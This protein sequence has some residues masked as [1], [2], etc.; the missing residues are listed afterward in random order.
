MMIRKIAPLAAAAALF[1]AAPAFAQS[2][3]DFTVGFGVHQVA[4]KSNNGKL[5]NNSVAVDVGNSLRPT[6]TGEYFVADNLG[7]EIIA[8]LPFSHEI[9]LAGVRA[10]ST[11]HLPPTLS[12]QYHFGATDAKVKP[13]LGAGVNYTYFYG[14]GLDNGAKL[15]LK[16]SWGAAAHA[17]IDF[18]LHERGAFR[19][20]VRWIDIDSKV[21]VGGA[22]VGTVNIDPLVYG[23]S[24]VLKF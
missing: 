20:D 16:N 2:K 4:P 21:R 7:V 11:K 18:A 23:A 3:G 14:E 24:Y 12:L 17:G 9:S 8:A 13:F 5:I 22:N 10:G 1:M 6:I 19:V 15:D